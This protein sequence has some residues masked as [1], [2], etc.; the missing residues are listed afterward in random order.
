MV[1]YVS[2]Y[3][4]CYRLLRYL[5]IGYRGGLQADD[6]RFKPCS[7]QQ[8][9][10]SAKELCCRGQRNEGKIICFLLNSYVLNSYV[11]HKL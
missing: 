2:E 4:S 8:L 11:L 3:V 1:R 5:L 10:S 9:S 6:A 7:C